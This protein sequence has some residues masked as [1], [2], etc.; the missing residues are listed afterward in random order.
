MATLADR[1]KI[2]PKSAFFFLGLMGAAGLHFGL[3]P[4]GGDLIPQI[5]ALRTDVEKDRIKLR[6]TQDRAANKAKF[7]EEVEQVSQ[8]FR[9]ALDYLPK[10]L[11]VQDL[12]KK[13]YSEARSAGV[14]L[15][16]FKPKETK[17][18]DFYDELP[19]DIVVKGNYP[20]LVTFLTNVSKLPRIINIMKVEIDK[21]EI[22]EGYPFMRMS[23]TLVGYRYKETK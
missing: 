14:D 15:L 10:E 17:Q 7:Q 9:L 23:G 12:L 21:P 5:E 20:Q 13:V 6:E 2:V 3:G 16:S 4:I 1:M 19:M 18:K 22:V 11:D 8:L